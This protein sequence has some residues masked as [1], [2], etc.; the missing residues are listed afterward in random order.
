[1]DK[2]IT[3]LFEKYRTN[4]LS[5][6]EYNSLKA[7]VSQSE[8]NN[9]TLV[10][11]IH[12]YKIKN[13][14]EMYQK[15]DANTAFV[16]ISQNYF[17]RRKVK[18]M[19]YAIAAACIFFIFSSI[20]FVVY[21]IKVN[22][23][24]LHTLNTLKSNKTVLFTSSDGLNEKLENG[25]ELISPNTVKNTPIYNTLR[26]QPGGNFKLILPDK[27]VVWMNGNTSI[28][29]AANFLGNRTI[30]LDG[31]AF[32]EVSKNGTPFFVK[33]VNN[34]IKVLG[35]KFNV[36]AYASRPI[37]TTLVAGSVEISNKHEQ[38]ILLPQQQA[39]SS[40]AG[41]GFEVKTVNTNIYTSWISG[42]FEFHNAPLGEI[43][44][45]LA[46]WYDIEIIYQN[47]QLK[48]LNFTGTLFRD[49]PITYS[50]QIIQ[51]VSNVKFRNENNRL[52]IY[53]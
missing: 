15:A 34:T 23:K 8:E 25:T 20:G 39:I 51:E 2:E 24:E 19:R 40:S 11:F 35:T 3:E 52:Y 17:K 42:V 36:S 16:T 27:S 46:Q 7:W 18:K 28:R 43:M 21:Q 45:Q 33:V 30:V 12:S 49:N 32:F 13:R 50:L 1:M 41:S 31:E 5:E 10:A 29:Y 37:V 14:W 22:D 4:K 53:K 26:T 38:L 6:L 47:S 9:K 44:E 48:N